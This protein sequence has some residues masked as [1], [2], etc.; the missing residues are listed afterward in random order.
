VIH[1]A[2]GDGFALPP[3]SARKLTAFSAALRKRADKID[4]FHSMLHI[5]VRPQPHRLP[6]LFTEDRP[7]DATQAA[8]PNPLP[9]GGSWRADLTSGF[10]VF[11][12]A[13]PLC[14]AI[15]L[16]SGYPATAG[17]FTAI[18]GGLLS[19][20][21]SNSALTIKGPAAGLIVIVLGCVLEFGGG[22]DATPEAR[23]QAYR[24]TLG[25]SVV[26]GLLQVAFALLRSGVV[27]ELF[28]S[29][30]VHGMLAAIGV[31]IM[32]KQI[33]HMLGVTAHAKEPLELIAEIPSLIP[34][35]NPEIAFIGLLNLLLLFSWS[36]LGIRGLKKIPAQLIVI[37][38]S[39]PL[40]YLFDLDHTHTYS[41]G[42]HSYEVG[43]KFL[44]NVPASIVS[45]ITLPDFS[46]V[47]TPT[48]VKWIVMFMLIGTL[49]SLLSAKAIDLLDPRRRKTDFNR[50]LLA[51][52]L[53]NTLAGFV[54]GLPMISE[55]VRSKAN[56]D[57]GAQTRFAN[58]FHGM[59]L[60]IFVALLPALIHRI[61]LAALA[62]MLVYTGFRLAHPRE[63]VHMYHRGWDQLLVFT[64][65]LVGVLATDL[66]IGVILGIA[67]K[68]A[69]HLFR[70]ASFGSFVKPQLEVDEPDE[71]TTRVRV[72]SSAVFSTWLTLRKTLLSIDAERT[73]ML[74][75]SEASL[76][77]SSTL[78][79]LSDLQDDFFHAGRNLLV[80]GLK[81]HVPIS[82]HPLATR[83]KSNES[84]VP[85]ATGV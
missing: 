48:G 12:I 26:A 76:V 32:A 62:A 60:L 83:K 30:A 11:L 59:F 61:P 1:R 73:V 49:E 56:L 22:L 45:A 14:L 13:L 78:G 55:I 77:D 85:S 10:L 36:A 57:N 70:G 3:S 17:V 68:C 79:K 24:L 71:F 75:L 16:A 80:I 38:I 42:G 58:L 64:T 52:G 7:M 44:V 54:G 2:D 23:L 20:W 21:I 4:P 53:G 28:P 15:S 72:H 19:P 5:E 37:V 82:T 29:S 81:G 25:I 46:G 6:G 41:F 33:P 51:V 27:S 9:A 74:D 67:L 47:A 18:I 35:M 34:E 39:I 40:G 31:I 65:T 66:L 8:Q 50:D 43:D 63:F 69:L 84:G